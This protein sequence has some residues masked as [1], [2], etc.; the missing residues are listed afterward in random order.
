MIGQ[1]AIVAKGRGRAAESRLY[2]MPIL[3]AEADPE[4]FWGER[5]L[6]KAGRALCRGRALRV[7][8]PRGFDRWP[9]LEGFG[10]RPVDPEPLIRAQSVPLALAALA[11]QGLAPDRATVALRGLRA[12][13][14]LARTAAE[15]CPNVRR[16]VVDAPWGGEELAQ[17]LRREFGIPVLPGR[18][19]GQV[20]LRF[21]EGAPR[22][23]EMSLGLYGPRP[24]LAG[25]ILAA[26]GL[27]EE[28]REALPLL[29]ALWEGGCLGQEDIKIT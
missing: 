7:L 3:R 21:Q 27:G 6:R 9:L 11:R 20:A 22:L 10:L 8:V 19:R 18:E 25:L 13:R 17:W 24:E 28:D 1:L 14:A 4:G 29:A 5:R 23:E 15:L 26:P 12:D 16:L 2:G